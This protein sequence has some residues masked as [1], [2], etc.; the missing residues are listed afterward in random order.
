MLLIMFQPLA[1][2]RD[3]WNV[4]DGNPPQTIM[5]F[6]HFLEPLCAIAK[7]RDVL[8]GVNKVLQRFEALPDRH[9][10]DD[11]WVIVVRNIGGISRFRLQSP[12]ESRTAIGKGIDGIKLRDKSAMRGSSMG[13]MNRPILIWARWWESIAR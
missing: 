2:F 4:S 10:D 7:R 9:I 13:A 3:G 5:R 8:R 11:E 12:H 6:V 1:A